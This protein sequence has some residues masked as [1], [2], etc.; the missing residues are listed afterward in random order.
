M[1]NYAGLRCPGC[2]SDKLRVLAN[3]WITLTPT[4]VALDA[5]PPI[6]AH[7]PVQCTDC[8]WDGPAQH[9]TVEE[10]VAGQ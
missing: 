10:T 4:G 9:L 1:S 6:E 8:G 7:A 2:D 3:L 5:S